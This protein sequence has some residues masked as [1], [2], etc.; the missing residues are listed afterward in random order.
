M[1]IAAALL[2][3]GCGL[4]GDS[5]IQAAYDSCDKSDSLEAGEFVVA[6]DGDSLIVEGTTDVDGL[7][8]ILGDLETPSTIVA[9]IDSTTAMMG[10]QREDADGLA[11]A[12]SYH[13]DT[14]IVM[15]IRTK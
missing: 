4:V 15:T 14:G 12:W 2:T 10:R 11:Y 8:C 6:D 9:D 5:R 7:A 1:A 13:P 3:A